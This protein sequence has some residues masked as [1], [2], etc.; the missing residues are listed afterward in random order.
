MY[1]KMAGLMRVNI[2][3]T[4]STGM[5]STSGQMEEYTQATGKKVSNTV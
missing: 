5:E 4:R 3:L 1:G 2:Y